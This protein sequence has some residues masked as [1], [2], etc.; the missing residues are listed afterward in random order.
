MFIVEQFSLPSDVR[1]D[2]PIIRRGSLST[3]EDR[4]KT[5]R[6]LTH[7]R[8]IRVLDLVEAGFYQ[9]GN[10]I[11]CCECKFNISE[12]EPHEDP[13][14]L[15]MMKTPCC[16]KH[17]SDDLKR[18]FDNLEERI[19]TYPLDW[20]S[21]CPIDCMKLAEAW[22]CYAGVDV[23]PHD[24][25]S[26]TVI[27][28]CCRVQVRRWRADDDPKKQHA[29]ACQFHYHQSSECAGSSGYATGSASNAPTV[30]PVPHQD[31]F[32]ARLDYGEEWMDDTMESTADLFETEI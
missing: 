22:F 27:C 10:E 4:T 25:R 31:S 7:F 17:T 14:V 32:E 15:H 29:E 8:Q 23:E 18:H 30:S 1:R 16:S 2:S 13:R 11:V 20:H 12:W 6:E 3:N 26:D 5:F 21:R 24:R 9:A 19:A 28:Y